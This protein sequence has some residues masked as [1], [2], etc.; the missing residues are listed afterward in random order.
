MKHD[1]YDSFGY[2]D[3]GGLDEGYL[4]TYRWGN[5]KYGRCFGKGSYSP[6]RPARKFSYRSK[7]TF[8]FSTESNTAD[9]SG[10]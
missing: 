8:G 1:I 4:N 6:N 9:K 10:I 3:K 5:P 7:P 2:S